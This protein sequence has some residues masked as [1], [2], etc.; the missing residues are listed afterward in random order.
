MSKK[1]DSYK[2]Y[3]LKPRKKGTLGKCTGKKTW[4]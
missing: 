2:M 1:K 3:L 4:K